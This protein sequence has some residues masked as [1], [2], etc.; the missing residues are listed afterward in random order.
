[1]RKRTEPATEITPPTAEEKA[2]FQKPWADNPSLRGK[3]R[4]DII[5]MV[6]DGTVS[7]ELARDYLFAWTWRKYGS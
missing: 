4:Q 3:Q 1:M 6:E 2:T 7:P 5:A